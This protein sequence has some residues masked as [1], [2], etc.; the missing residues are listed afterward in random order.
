MALKA[1][2]V[3]VLLEEVDEYGH[4]INHEDIPT[5]DTFNPSKSYAE[6]DVVIYNNLV[7]ESLVNN[8]IGHV[9]TDTNYWKPTTIGSIISN[10]NKNSKIKTMI[11]DPIDTGITTYKLRVY[12]AGNVVMVHFGAN[13]DFSKT[14]AG[15]NIFTPLYEGLPLPLVNFDCIQATLYGESFIVG[16]HTDGK[17]SINNRGASTNVS[18]YA[19]INFVYLVE[20]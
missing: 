8:N 14:Q 1:G 2:R 10:I 4:I 9:V 18:R 11:I 5:G 20:V 17:L 12:Q 7:Y 6:G 3:G 15:E 16:V 13:I 19:Y